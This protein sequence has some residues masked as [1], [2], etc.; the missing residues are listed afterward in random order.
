MLFSFNFPA[1]RSIP[2]FYTFVI[3][4]SRTICQVGMLMLSK[5]KNLLVFLLEK[6][7]TFLKKTLLSKSSPMC[8]VYYSQGS[9][10][11][12][13]RNFQGGVRWWAPCAL[14][15]QKLFN[16]CMNC[17]E[18]LRIHNLHIP[19]AFP[20]YNYHLLPNWTDGPYWIDGEKK[21]LK[22]KLVWSAPLQRWWIEII[23]VKISVET[24][25]IFICL[26][27]HLKSSSLHK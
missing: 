11:S 15:S 3:S 20:L 18:N 25:E 19:Y 2:R 6:F 1:S 10:I 22:W 17:K 23:D 24:F 14:L 26:K 27:W 13:F 21:K 7:K 8:T 5:S 4:A 12:F 9:L 16:K